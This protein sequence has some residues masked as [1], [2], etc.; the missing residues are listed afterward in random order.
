MSLNLLIDTQS[1]IWHIA[2]QGAVSW[3]HFLEMAQK[4]T[5]IEGLVT[6]CPSTD[7]GFVA[8]RPLYS[9][10]ASKHGILLP[11]LEDAITDYLRSRHL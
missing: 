9:V 8:T 11:K 5:G 7:F 1:G 6:G 10:L 4:K 2:N 3:M